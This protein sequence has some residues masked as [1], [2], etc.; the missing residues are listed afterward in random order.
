MNPCDTGIAS[1]IC[2]LYLTCSLLTVGV[3]LPMFAWLSLYIGL[4][5]KTQTR[6]ITGALAAILAW[7]VA[8]LVFVAMPLR[9]MLD[10][11]PDSGIGFL[12]LLSP[13][14]IIEFNEESGWRS[15]ANYPWVAVS[16]NFAAYG[17]ILVWLRKLCYSHADRLLGRVN[18][19]E[20]PDVRA[21]GIE[22]VETPEIEGWLAE[23]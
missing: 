2:L 7:C 11:G 21:K 19:G 20:Q 13:A 4:R 1:S 18:V 17:L 16:V 10:A 12:L 15:L 3:Y 8:P 9:I 23:K 22:I 6:A 5:V 14:S